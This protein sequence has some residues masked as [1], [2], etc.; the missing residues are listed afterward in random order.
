MKNQNVSLLCTFQ[1]WFRWRFASNSFCSIIILR[2]DK[3]KVANEEFYC[4]KKTINKNLGCWC[5]WDSYLKLIETKNTSSYLIE[6]LNDVIGSLV[7][8]L[9]N[10]WM[11]NLSKIT[12]M[13]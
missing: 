9:P 13:N 12:I 7:S 3:K 8:T 2:F 10:E 6:Y 1:K 11:L 5:W 4:T